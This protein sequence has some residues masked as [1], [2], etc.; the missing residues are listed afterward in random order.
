MLSI[1]LVFVGGGIGAAIRYWMYGAVQRWTGSTFPYGTFTVNAL[2][3]LVI[4]VLMASM[5]ERFLINPSLRLFLTVG[6]LGGF[7]T[8][9]TFS[10]ETVAMLHDAE[11]FYAAINICMTFITCIA[12][13]YIGTVVGKIL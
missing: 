12:T 3:C 9:S 2:G 7:T 4:G 1:G 8:F 5:E 10:Y 6:I 13:T 11:Y